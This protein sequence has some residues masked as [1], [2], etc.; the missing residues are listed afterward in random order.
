VVGVTSGISYEILDLRHFMAHALRPLLEAEERVWAER[1]H[2]DY[3][4][5]AKLLLQYL[6]GRM[7][8]GYAA[9][10]RG[11]GTEQGCVAGY[12]FCV[13]EDTKAV[14]GDVFADP[15]LER[16]QSSSGGFTGQTPLEVEETLLRHLLETLQHSPHVNRIESQLLVHPSGRHDEAFRAAGFNLYRRLFMTRSLKGFDEKARIELPAGLEVRSWRDDDMQAAS[17]LISDCYA[18]HPDSHINDQ[19]RTPI[20]SLRFLQ[21]IVRFSGCGT[22][23]PSVSHLVTEHGS[24]EP[25][26]LVLGSRVSAHSGHITQ[27]CVRPQDRKR[28]LGRALLAI[29]GQG[30]MKQDIHEISLTVTEANENAVELYRREG[31]ETTHTFDAGVWEKN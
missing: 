7:L 23:S 8:P 21:N 11:S 31:Y 13:Y 29:A 28:G 4:A 9:V 17:R 14:V 16:R 2:W 1:L 27:L 10:D 25:V 26:A 18:G 24:R 30:F 15:D 12:A 20:G 22:F 5:S 19:Y 6:D 3:R